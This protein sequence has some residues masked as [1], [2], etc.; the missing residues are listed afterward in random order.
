VKKQ[1]GVFEKLDLQL[2][3]KIITLFGNKVRFYD[4]SIKMRRAEKEMQYFSISKNSE[5]QDK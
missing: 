4:H 1:V 5:M 2:R 3:Q